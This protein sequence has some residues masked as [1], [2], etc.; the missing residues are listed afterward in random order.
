ML[1][2]KSF[3][4]YVPHLGKSETLKPREII[5]EHTFK[6]M[7]GKDELLVVS[8]ICALTIKFFRCA[9]TVCISI[10]SGAVIL[11]VPRGGPM[12]SVKCCTGYAIATPFGT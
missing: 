9:E 10:I 1:P 8:W 11:K 3:Q 7:V 6:I 12:P 4:L 2:P 5:L